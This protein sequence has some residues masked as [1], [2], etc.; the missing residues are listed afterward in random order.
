M[1]DLTK[2]VFKAILICSSIRNLSDFQRQFIVN[3]CSCIIKRFPSIFSSDFGHLQAVS[4][5]SCLLSMILYCKII[6]KYVTDVFIN[7]FPNEKLTNLNF[8]NLQ[9]LVTKQSE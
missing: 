5:I 9:C 1:C 3:L 6:F 4:G 2:M 7:A 8:V